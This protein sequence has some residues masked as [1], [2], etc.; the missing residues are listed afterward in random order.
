M[1]MMKDPMDLDP[2]APDQIDL[3]RKIDAEGAA[4]VDQILG[5]CTAAV[6][7]CS[8]T[9]FGGVG[10]AAFQRAAHE[11]AVRAAKRPDDPLERIGAAALWRAVQYMQGCYLESE[12]AATDPATVAAMLAMRPDL[13]G[14]LRSALESRERGQ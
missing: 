7:S 1:R 8:A 3:T 4:S 10:C 2:M 12:R 6:A 11:A 14:P 9:L 5:M 13:E